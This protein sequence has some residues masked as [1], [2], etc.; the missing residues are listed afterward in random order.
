MGLFDSFRISASALTAQ[1]LR[2]DIIA[3][4]MANA[5]TTRTAEGGPYKKEMPVFAESRPKFMLPVISEDARST[6]GDGVKVVAIKKDT[7]PPKLVYNPSHPDANADGYVAMP[8][9]ELV[10]EMVDMIEATRAYEANV[11]ALNSSKSM[12]VKALEIGRA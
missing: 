12:A 10:S 4:N 6:V 11:T 2:M 1:R 3:N 5:E 8:N 7:A 9:I